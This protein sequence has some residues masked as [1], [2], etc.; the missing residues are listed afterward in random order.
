[1]TQDLRYLFCSETGCRTKAYRKR[2]FAA[3][4][5]THA[6]FLAFFVRLVDP[7]F[8]LL[9]DRFIERLGRVQSRSEAKL[10][11]RDFREITQRDASILRVIFRLRVSSRKASRIAR[12]LLPREPKQEAQRPETP[13][14]PPDMH[15]ADA[16]SLRSDDKEW[17]VAIPTH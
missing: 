13:I 17:D 15:L 1:M 5:P 6:R 14:L 10:A 7:R 8:F 4:L 9:D 12:S 16:P 3:C 2:M 11:V